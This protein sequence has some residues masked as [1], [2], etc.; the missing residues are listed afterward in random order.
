MLAAGDLNLMKPLFTMY[1]LTLPLRRA[2]TKR[3]Y[4]HDGVLPRDDEFSGEPTPT[5]ITA[6]TAPV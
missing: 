1:A 5:R 3:Y 2:A 4:G 6:R